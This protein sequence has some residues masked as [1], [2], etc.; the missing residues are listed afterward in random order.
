MLVSSEMALSRYPFCLFTNPF[1]H[2]IVHRFPGGLNRFRVV[3]ALQCNDRIIEATFLEIDA[4]EIERTVG[5]PKALDLRETPP[6][7]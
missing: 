6:R 3:C 1:N 5:T 4:C 7:A 2:A